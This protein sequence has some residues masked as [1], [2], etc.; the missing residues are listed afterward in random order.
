MK[1][2]VS[3]LIEHRTDFTDLYDSTIV[4]HNALVDTIYL[5]LRMSCQ[6]IAQLVAHLTFNVKVRDLSPVRHGNHFVSFILDYGLNE[7]DFYDY[8]YSLTRFLQI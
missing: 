7:N 5:S 1:C 8:P 2:V 6:N 3:K 4:I